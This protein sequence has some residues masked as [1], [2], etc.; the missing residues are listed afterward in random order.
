MLAGMQLDV[1]TPLKDGPMSGARLAD[2]LD[3]PQEKLRPLLYPLEE[4]RKNKRPSFAVVPGVSAMGFVA[5]LDRVDNRK[6][7]ACWLGKSSRLSVR[8]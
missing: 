2:A 7:A 5:D 4:V 3:V 1:F 8:Q 6:V